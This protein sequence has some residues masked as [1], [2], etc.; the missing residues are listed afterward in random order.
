MA[1]VKKQRDQFIAFSFSSADLFLEVSA[2][3]EIVFA[4]GA[5]VGL[6]GIKDTSLV[7][8]QWLDVFCEA[9]RGLLRGMRAKAQ[10][11]KRCGPLPV[12]MDEELAGSAK[13]I[14]TGIKMP[15]PDVFYLSIGFTNELMQKVADALRAQMSNDLMDKQVFIKQAAGAIEMARSLGTELEMTFLDVA[16]AAQVKNRIGDDVWAT[17]QDTAGAF[18]LSQSSDG[19]SAAEVTEGRYSVIHDKSVDSEALRTQLFNISKE[20]DPE[21]KGFSVSSTSVEADMEGLSEH[22]A[23][24]ALI[25]T[26]NEFERKGTT[27]DIET[28]QG[29][30]KTYAA[31]NAQ[32]IQQF[33]EII[34]RSDFDFH[35][36][37][38]V[39]FKKKDVSHFEMLARFKTHE[40]TQEWVVFGE[41]VGMAAE[42]DIAVC[43][44]AINYLLYKGGVTRNKFAINLSGQSIQNEQFFKTLLAKLKANKGLSDRLIFEI[45]E[46]TQIKKLDVV[47]SFVQR[48]KKDGFKVCL[49]D[50][51]AGAA[52]F[53]YLQ[54]L[55]VN[56][57][58]ID[59]QYTRRLLESD[60]EAVMIKS[61]NKMCHD[62]GVQVVVEQIETKE[63]YDKLK[64][65]GIQLG[66]GYY[67]GHPEPHPHYDTSLFP[68]D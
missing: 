8:K 33:K 38:I 10:L 56:Y 60:R 21:G 5:A 18:L 28:L 49:D 66:Q 1:D 63:Q 39:D 54:K 19:E 43:E 34:N 23:M 57:V 52:S 46:S 17:F 44:R 25:Y 32:R 62:L 65:L 37:P 22:D 27:L 13:A 14:V 53:Q 6:T 7:G 4:L 67:F 48:L 64:G 61:L 29:G 59:G 50:F 45:T 20:A 11:A 31:A 36:Q 58:K 26:I 2:E 42:F 15:G 40:S 3:G 68:S 55:H 47:S 51:G 9:D 12:T 30:L 16:D 35:Y 24:K 41:D